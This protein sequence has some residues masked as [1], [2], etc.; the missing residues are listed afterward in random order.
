MD[1]IDVCL[2]VSEDERNNVEEGGTAE[3]MFMT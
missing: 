3:L 2:T 1:V